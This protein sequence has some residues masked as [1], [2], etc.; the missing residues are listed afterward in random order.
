MTDSK[1]LPAIALTA[2][3]LITAEHNRAV[4]VVARQALDVMGLRIEDGWKVNVGDGV[5]M[6]EVKDEA[7]ETNTEESGAGD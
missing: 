2:I 6:R 7:T 5:A 1:P 3:Q 4:D